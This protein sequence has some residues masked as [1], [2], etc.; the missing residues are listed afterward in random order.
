LLVAR[1]PSEKLARA[2]KS[3]AKYRQEIWEGELGKGGVIGDLSGWI[4]RRS[5]FYR[6]VIS[7]VLSPSGPTKNICLPARRPVRPASPSRKDGN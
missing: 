4:V 6:P 2:V 1:K 7:G 3:M 5:A